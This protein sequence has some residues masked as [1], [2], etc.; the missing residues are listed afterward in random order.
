MGV[1]RDEVARRAGVSSAVVSY[2]LNG[3]PRPV[4]AATRARVLEAMRELDYR[5]NGVARALR[6]RRT[7]ALGLIIPDSSNPFFAQ[8]ARAIEDAAQER[9]FNLLV[10]NAADDP[11]R[12]VRYV[13]T[14]VERRV[15]GLLLISSG[16][17]AETLAELDLSRTPLVV[18]DRMPSSPP[19]AVIV[20]DNEIGGRLA[21]RH[22]LEHGHEVVGCIAGPSH[23]TPSD[24]RRRG[25]L[26]VLHEAGLQV[27][28]NLVVRAPFA[29]DA[30]YRVARRMLRVRPR[31]TAIFASSDTQAIGALRAAF[32]EG[33]HVPGD[34]A[35]I[36][37]D[38]IPEAHYTLPSLATV[39]Q[40]IAAI[41]RLTVDKV[42]ARITDRDA[43]ATTDVLPVR[44]LPGGSCGCA[45]RPVPSPADALT[46]HPGIQVASEGGGQGER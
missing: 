30:G 45:D 8:L 10:G 14:F 26:A 38:G 22:L 32:E 24:D 37:F 9:G 15:D 3:G 6:A 46:S 2:V 4:A 39:V 29:R 12:E 43:P 5:P 44:L 31:P 42:L 17:A 16:D 35:V 28:P 23:L 27:D 13:R 34:I 25:F 7:N 20:A 21:T 11:E 1:T 40:P 36:G 18:V 19:A 33:L 41:A